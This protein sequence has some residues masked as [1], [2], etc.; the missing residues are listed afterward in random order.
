MKGKALIIIDLQEGIGQLYP[1][2][3][4]AWTTILARNRQLLA[5]FLEQDA[6]VFLVSVQPDRF[7][8]L[9]LQDVRATEIVKMVPSAFE[10]ETMDLAQALENAGVSQVFISGVSTSNGV[11]KTARSAVAAGFEATIVEDASGAKTV[12]LHQEA[13]QEI[14]TI[15]TVELLGL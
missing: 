4:H 12:E 1:T 6:P 13:C 8:P 2:Q 9:I 15:S 3:P 5:H 7:G 10:N 14:G 11:V